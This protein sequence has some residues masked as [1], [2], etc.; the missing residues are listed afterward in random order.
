MLFR[1]T[2]APD[3]PTMSETLLPGFSVSPWFGFFYPAKTSTAIVDK[4]FADTT[5]QV[6]SAPDVRQRI[7]DQGAEIAP[8]ASKQE[9][10]AFVAAEHAQWRKTVDEVMGA[11]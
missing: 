2:A 10:A 1:S 9:F 6:L 11:K 5:R 8:S 7:I 3:V 4:L